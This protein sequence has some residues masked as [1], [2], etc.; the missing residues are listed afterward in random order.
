MNTFSRPV[1][2]LGYSDVALRLSGVREPY[3][4]YV[5]D[6]PRPKQNDLFGR[7]NILSTPSI[8]SSQNMGHPLNQY[9]LYGNFC[10]G[11]AITAF[12]RR[13]LVLSHSSPAIGAIIHCYGTFV[14]LRG[15]VNGVLIKLLWSHLLDGGIYISNLQARLDC[16][17]QSYP[18]S[19]S[20]ISLSST[21]DLS[22][23]SLKPSTGRVGAEWDPRP[24][25]R[26]CCPLDW[27][28]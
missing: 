26:Y 7:K 3:R 24:F 4:R 14:I 12:G 8:F 1:F 17:P 10:Q 5:I 15:E 20:S 16:G 25:P 23:W 11:G 2:C 13:S 6:P 19:P 9:L 27:V 22:K 18:T 28:M 21:S